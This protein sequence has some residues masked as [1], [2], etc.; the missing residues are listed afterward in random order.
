MKNCH[1]MKKTI[2]NSILKLIGCAAI[3]V[4]SAS[5]YDAT[6]AMKRIENEKTSQKN[7]QEMR[8]KSDHLSRYG[9]ARASS[10]G[11]VTIRG[12]Q[13]MRCALG[14][15]WDA[16]ASRCDGK[17][18][19]VSAGRAADL[20]GDMNRQGG[21]AGRKDWRMP[22]ISELETLR[23][24]SSGVTSEVHGGTTFI[25]KTSKNVQDRKRVFQMCAGTHTS[26]TVNETFF[27]GIGRDDWVWSTT[28]G[29]GI[30]SSTQ[31]IVNFEKGRVS[32]TPN[33]HDHGVLLV[34]TAK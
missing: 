5:A 26:P 10:D 20:P 23:L 7:N 14:Q 30:G 34:R 32:W 25:P 29:D 9:N 11:T 22:T 2:F 13:W 31:W 33:Y 19:E 18:I 24:C 16:Q 28:P 17:I 1:T 8:K 15:N 12:L 27:P 21:F 3:P 6:E 4:F